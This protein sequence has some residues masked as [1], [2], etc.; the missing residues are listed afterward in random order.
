MGYSI[1]DRRD[2]RDRWRAEHRATEPIITWH[3]ANWQ[4]DADD[5]LR[6][7]KATRKGDRQLL[8]NDSAIRAIVTFAGWLRSDEGIYEGWGAITRLRRPVS[9]AELLRDQRTRHRFDRSGIHAFQGGPIGVNPALAQAISDLAAGIPPTPLPQSELNYSL[10]PILWAGPDGLAP[11]SYIEAAVAATPRLWRQLGFQHP[12]RRQAR[13]GAAGRPDLLD[14]DVVGEAKR[15]VTVN[16]GPGQI[17]RY[18][19]YLHFERGRQRSRLRGV[20]L[21]RAERT[22]Q[23]VIDRIDDSEYR[24]E[25]WAVIDDDGYWEL[26]QLF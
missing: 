18:L 23:A 1:Y 19:D 15:A 20:L 2:E 4:G 3:A 24:L 6:C 22:S 12:P 7:L 14:G 5:W 26:D 8:W 16:S 10:E 21:Q 11:E 13:L 17:E 9:R 25:L